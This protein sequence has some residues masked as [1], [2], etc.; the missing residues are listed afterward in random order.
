MEK[1]SRSSFVVDLDCSGRQATDAIP[2]TPSSSPVGSGGRLHLNSL[3]S[4]LSSRLGMVDC[5]GSSPGRHLPGLDQPSPRLLVRRLGRGAGSSSPGRNRFRPLVSGGSS[6]VHKRKG[7]PYGGVRSPAFPSRG[8]QLHGSSV[9]GQFD[10]LGLPSQT[11]G[12]RSPV[13]NSIA[14]RILRWA[15]S[16]DLVLK[17]QFIQGKNNVLADSLS[18]PNQVQGSEWTL[19]WEVFREL[20]NKWPVMID[21]F[22]TSL[23]HHCSLYFSSFRDPSAI[24]TDALLQN[25]DGYQVYAF[26]PWSMIPLVLKK[27]RSSS[28]VLMTLNCSILA[29]ETMISGPPGT[30]G[31]RSDQYTEVSRSPQPTALP[32]SSSRDRQAVP[33]CL[34][35]IQRFARSQGFS[36]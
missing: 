10:S 21:L 26:P 25:W 24:G 6:T 12:T 28:G 15:E 23:N 5:S 36:S 1:A 13:L 35:T 31:G 14:Q 19:K 22:A 8:G 17:P 2:P 4:G 27:L 7:A 29:S 30:S 16:I 3:G 18:R 9:C 32:L 33:S 34:E 11:G 20:N